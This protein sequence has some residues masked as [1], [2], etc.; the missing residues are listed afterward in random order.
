MEDV[1]EGIL[2]SLERTYVHGPHSETLPVFIS[3][4]LQHRRQKE[5]ILLGFGSGQS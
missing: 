1:T 2:T 4:L 5:I 3:A